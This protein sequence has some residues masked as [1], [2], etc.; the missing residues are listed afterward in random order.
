MFCLPTENTTWPVGDVVPL[1]AVTVAVRLIEEPWSACEAEEA[2]AV[3]VLTS[4][5]AGF[6]TTEMLTG[7]DVDF[8]KAELPP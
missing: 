3:D 4:A 1:A 5:T 7:F 2:T 6:E 8:R